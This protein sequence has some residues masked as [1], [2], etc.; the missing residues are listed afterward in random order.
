M[1]KNILFICLLFSFHAFSQ[2]D[3]A[4]VKTD[5]A[6]V[7]LPGEMKQ[8]KT[9]GGPIMVFN[10]QRLINTNTVDVLSKGVMEFRVSHNFDDI[11]GSNGGI[12]HFWGLDNSTDIR[13]GFQIGLCK[14][15][16]IIAA[17]AKGSARPLQ[18]CELGIKHQLLHQELNDPR[19]PHSI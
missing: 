17:R 1:R 8:K 3:S 16:N 4:A 13:I 9:A 6:V 5:T 2:N 11:A 15:F 14:N 19:H 10:S 12:K 7:K 18:L